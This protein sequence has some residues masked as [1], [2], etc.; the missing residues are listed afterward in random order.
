MGKQIP[1][2]AAALTAQTEL[3]VAEYLGKDMSKNMSDD[4]KQLSIQRVEAYEQ[5][6]R[7]IEGFYGDPA[8][9]DPML[10]DEEQLKNNLINA[11]RKTDS[12]AVLGVYRQAEMVGLFSFLTLREEQYIEM[13]VG[14]SRD[15]EAYTDI[16]TYLEQHYP[17]CNADFVFNPNNYLLKEAL[18]QKSAQFETEQ[19]KMVLTQSTPRVDT[20]DIE[21]LSEPYMQQYLA[22]HSQDVYWTGEKVAAAAE[23]FRTLL[24][25]EDGKVVGYIDVTHCFEENEPFDLFVLESHRRKGC[26]RKLLAKAIYMNKPNGMILMIEADNIPAIRLYESMGFEKAENQNSLSAHWRIPTRNSQ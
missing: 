17:S 13:L 5:C 23:K 18:A 4:I 15:S 9:S 26:G 12:H 19:Q 1:L 11:L 21:L 22:I 8:F 7:F 10:S 14:L 16:I 3:A 24:A 20:A 25:I 2:T 6:S